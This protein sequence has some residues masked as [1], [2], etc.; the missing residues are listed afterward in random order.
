MVAARWINRDGAER[1]ARLLVIG[2]I[3]LTLASGAALT[4]APWT[5]GLEPTADVYD[6]TVWVLALWTAVHLAVGVLMQAY[7]VARSLAGKLTSEHD[8]DLQNTVL[9]GHFATITL[10]TTV[11]V[12][13]LFPLVA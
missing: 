6:A 8:I 10:V 7:C 13:A 9:Y 11:L 3:P 12:I 4:W 5:T 2:S 1:G